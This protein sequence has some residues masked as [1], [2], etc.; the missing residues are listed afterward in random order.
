LIAWYALAKL[1]E[2]NDDAVFHLTQG[3]ISGHSLKHLAACMAA[4]PV[5]AALKKS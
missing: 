4:W 1:L 5:L 3:I 2:A